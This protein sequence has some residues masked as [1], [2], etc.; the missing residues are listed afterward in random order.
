LDTV[1]DVVSGESLIRLGWRALVVFDPKSGR[2][3]ELRDA[4]SD[5]RGNSPDEAEEVTEEYVCI[6]YGIIPKDLPKLRASPHTWEH[7]VAAGQFKNAG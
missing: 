3:V 6:T 2:L 5:V 1:V 7:V 4:P